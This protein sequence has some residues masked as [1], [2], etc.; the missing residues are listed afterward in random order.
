MNTSCKENMSRYQG[1]KHS[2]VTKNCRK[3]FPKNYK[4]NFI[5]RIVPAA[6]TNV[7]SRSII[8]KYDSIRDEKEQC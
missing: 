6:I 5:D 1:R 3:R 7:S 4:K 8:N 2:S